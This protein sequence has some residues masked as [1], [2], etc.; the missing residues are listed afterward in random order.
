[1]KNIL[2]EEITEAEIAAA[3]AGPRPALLPALGSPL[4]ARVA[5][6][7]MAQSLLAPLRELAERE[8]D[9][10]LPLLTDELYAAYYTTGRR[11][12]FD[13]LYLERHRRVG[14]AALCA[15]LAPQNDSDRWVRSFIAKL[16]EIFE[17]PSWSLPAHVGLDNPTGKDPQMIDLACAAAADMMSEA[18]TLFGAVLPASLVGAIKQRLNEQVFQNYISTHERFVWV[19]IT[20]NWN[21]VCHQGVIG[22]A[23]ALAD[24]DVCA[25][26]LMIARSYLPAFLSG[27]DED[28]GA[29][30]G[31]SYWNYGFGHFAVMNDQIE[32]SSCGALSLFDRDEHIRQ[33]ALYPCRVALFAGQTVNFS[34]CDP[35]V[36]INPRVLTYLGNRLGEDS[37][38]GLAHVEFTKLAKDGLALH[39]WPCDLFYLTQLC[40]EIPETI[41]SEEPLSPGSFYFSDMQV[42]V[43]RSIDRSGYKWTL[44]PRVAT[45]ASTTTITIVAATC[46]TS[47]ANASSSRLVGRSIHE[48]SLPTSGTKT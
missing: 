4:W 10:P 39:G 47:T 26:I 13:S 6:N 15:L 44:R 11:L 19:T 23:L 28:G 20:N 30:E 12:E 27:F 5:A 45:M 40:R 33:I 7:P 43:T 41:M 35:H 8:I 31:L 37:L 32:T 42:L 16:M 18:V 34:D 22:A 1:M 48:T 14:R 9:E 2:R 24:A 21:A 36:R 3:L 25:Q 17:E 38:I 29:R 46:S